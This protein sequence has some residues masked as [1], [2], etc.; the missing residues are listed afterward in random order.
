MIVGHPDLKHCSRRRRQ[1]YGRYTRDRNR[2]VIVQLRVYHFIYARIRC[3]GSLYPRQR[4]PSR[5]HV[6]GAYHRQVFVVSPGDVRKPDQQRH[7]HKDE[8]QGKLY[9]RLPPS[10]VRSLS[11]Q[12]ADLQLEGHTWAARCRHRPVTTGLDR[13]SCAIYPARVCAWTVQAR[14][15]SLVSSPPRW[16]SPTL[17]SETRHMW[18]RTTGNVVS[19]AR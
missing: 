4:G 8:H 19:G 11:M 3:A 6:G 1:N 10:R 15:R 5:S 12:L 17:P 7:K 18:V 13:A 9:G 2:H 16:R 14:A